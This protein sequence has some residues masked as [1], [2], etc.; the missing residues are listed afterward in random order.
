[1]KYLLGLDIG[2]SATKT[3]LFDE[4]MKVIASASEEYPMYQPQNGWAEQNPKDWYN[5]SLHT[6]QE[7][8]VKSK[9]NPEDVKI[10]RCVQF[11]LIRRDHLIFRCRDRTQKTSALC[12]F[13][14]PHP[15]HDRRLSSK[16]S[17]RLNH[18]S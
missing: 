13:L 2:T 6:I 9:I 11:I 10:P 8:L 15:T 17:D 16:I 4:T 18:R 1:M 3:V 5:A 12:I 7:V 14:Y